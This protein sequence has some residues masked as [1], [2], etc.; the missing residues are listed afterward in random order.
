MKYINKIGMMMLAATM[1]TVAS[2]SDFNDYNETPTDA[3]PAGNQTLWQNISQ[4]QELT[5]FAALVEKS[6]FNTELDKS[7]SYTIWAPKNGSFNRSAFDQLSKEDL[8]QQF[9]KNHIAE[10]GHVASGLLNK[11]IHTL[12]EK[13]YIFEGSGKYTFDGIAISQPNMP[14]S[15]GIIHLMDRYAPFYY[16]LYEYL[17][18]APDIDSL[19]NHLMRYEQ[20]YLDE[21]AS[22][23]GPMVDGM[24]TYIDS[25]MITTNLMLF[26]SLGGRVANE[27]SSYTF[28]MPTSEAFM[29]M[30]DKVKSYYNFA[31]ETT[32]LDVA[33]FTSATDT[34]SV[35]V[36]V[37]A[38][39]LRDSLTRLTIVS[40]LI[41]SNND[42]YNQWIVGKGQQTDSIRSTL[43]NKF[44][45]PNELLS[46][47]LV[48]EPVTLSNGYARIVDSLAFKPWELYCPEIVVNPRNW[49]A[50]LFPASA[51]ANKNQSVPDSLVKK[52][53]GPDCDETNFRYMWISPGGDRAKSDFAIEL[54]N[55]ASATYNFYVVFMPSA[56]KQFGND[57]RPNWLNFELNYANAKG[58]TAKY[59]FSKAYADSLL[60]GGTLPKL[61]TS[62]G[63]A[64]AF[65]N[66][67]EKADTV[68]IGRF[69]F[70]VAYK[71]LG[72]YYPSI[73][74]TSPIS[75]FN[76]THLETY[77][78]DVRI[79]AILMRP[80]ELDEFEAK[81]K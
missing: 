63:T 18:V 81:Q 67:P 40:N 25:V 15:N 51:V 49:L 66:N 24:Q 56:W 50:N 1:L 45:N 34:K 11:R 77:S 27:D 13:S 36:K 43:R 72:N 12:N 3:L 33:N 2:C 73:R 54:P 58:A 75:V 35:P 14:S 65:T 80:V 30:Y 69:T 78:R 44:S 10:Y 31:D 8:L 6:G 52:V 37:D 55:V 38:A 61:P 70:P 76:K 71:G 41:Y 22:V 16:N 79:A 57:P 19:R 7:R 46:D 74:V 29:K 60:T 28:I 48:G 32:V 20:T 53:F 4:N 59:F 17:K 9:V 23:K 62:V 68:F 5:D 47:Y 42:G 21:S 26:Y 39:Y 64:T